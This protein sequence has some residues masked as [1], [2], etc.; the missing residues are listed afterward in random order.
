MGDVVLV[1]GET[2]PANHG[3]ESPKRR[4][5][6]R[7]PDD[8]LILPIVYLDCLGFERLGL[9]H[10]VIETARIPLPRAISRS[11]RRDS[12]RSMHVKRLVNAVFIL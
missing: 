5:R 7:T 12:R 6:E 4:E 2:A 8:R 9:G 11:S 1:V 3:D 10:K